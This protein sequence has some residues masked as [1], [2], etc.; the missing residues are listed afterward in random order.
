MLHTVLFAAATISSAFCHKLPCVEGC[1]CPE[2]TY[3]LEQRC[4]TKDDC[5]CRFEDGV[6]FPGSQ[7]SGDCQNC[8]CVNGDWN[9][10]VRKILNCSR[11][12]TFFCL[13]VFRLPGLMKGP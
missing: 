12:L 4:V 11:I 2:G 3:K 9:C 7:M 10:V 6:Y 13:N 1:F 5:P 8:T